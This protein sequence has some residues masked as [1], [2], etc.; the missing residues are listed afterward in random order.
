MTPILMQT[1]TVAIPTVATPDWGA[2]AAYLFGAGLGSFILCFIA[3]V[4]PLII[5][6]A[7]PQHRAY[8]CWAAVGMAAYM[9]FAS[10]S[11]HLEAKEDFMVAP[12]LGGFVIYAF[13]VYAYP[14]KGWR[15][16]NTW[17]FRRL[18]CITARPIAV[19]KDRLLYPDKP[20][21]KQFHSGK[22][23]RVSKPHAKKCTTSPQKA[24]HRQKKR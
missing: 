9:T 22:S 23:K 12:T 17:L 11:R 15:L 4:V 24:H 20:V 7:L 2:I 5:I 13:L 21:K 1:P 10:V 3:G 6:R 18:A 16:R 19:G 14:W 8:L